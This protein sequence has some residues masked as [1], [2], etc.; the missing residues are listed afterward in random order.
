MAVQL[1]FMNATLW[2]NFTITLSQRWGP[3][4][5]LRSQEEYPCTLPSNRIFEEFLTL[6]IGFCFLQIMRV[7]REQFYTASAALR[8]FSRVFMHQ[9]DMSVLWKSTCLFI[10]PHMSNSLKYCLDLEA[11]TSSSH[12]CTV[13]LTDIDWSLLV[14]TYWCY[15]EGYAVDLT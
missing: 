14:D 2:S 8:T 4:Q 6:S 9:F 15:W 10:E 1:K 13:S 11:F 7:R 12:P 3:F 5:R